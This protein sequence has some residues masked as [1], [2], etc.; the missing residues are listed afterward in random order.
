MTAVFR[1]P[2][3]RINS[4][5]TGFAPLTRRRQIS[6]LSEI[7]RSAP[8]KP[9]VERGRHDAQ[10]PCHLRARQVAL[11]Q[12]LRD[13]DWS[14]LRFSSMI[15]LARWVRRCCSV[16]VKRRPPLNPRV[17]PAPPVRSSVINRPSPRSEI[18]MPPANSIACWHSRIEIAGGVREPQ[19]CSMMA[20][21]RPV[22]SSCSWWVKQRAPRYH[23][24]LRISIAVVFHSTPS[25]SKGIPC[26]PSG[27]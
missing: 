27:G 17:F 4:S 26:W 22:S 15:S 2:A 6:A 8:W 16:T 3:V 13:L 9:A 19:S 12:R 5:S 25:T 14:A 24:P 18:L 10:L 23:R 21:A 20:R 11:Q 7:C 1:A